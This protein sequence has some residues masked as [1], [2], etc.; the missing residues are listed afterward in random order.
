MHEVW[1]EWKVVHAQNFSDGKSYAIIW[2]WAC[3][4]ISKT[5]DFKWGK[6]IGDTN[7]V[8]PLG[9]GVQEELGDLRRG[10]DSPKREDVEQTLE[11][12]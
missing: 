2:V 10:K 7:G 12:I 1:N 6:N 4:F 5:R 8:G 11:R 9:V 3:S